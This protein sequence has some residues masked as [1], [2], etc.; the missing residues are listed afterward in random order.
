MNREQGPRVRVHCRRKWAG[1]GIPLARDVPFVGARGLSAATLKHAHHGFDVD[2]PGKD[3]Y[4][5]RRAG[6]G[7]VIV[8]SSRRWVQMH[9]IGDEPPV[10]LAQLLRRLSPCDLVLIEGFKSEAHPKIEIYRASVGKP[11]LHPQ[12]PHV[13][14]VASDAPVPG[15]ALPSLDLNDVTAIADFAVARAVPMAQVLPRLDVAGTPVRR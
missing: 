1:T 15:L 10:T 6:A 11:P 12:D 9:E 14:A 7:E 8:F 13:L 2:L 4:E 3:S 5:H